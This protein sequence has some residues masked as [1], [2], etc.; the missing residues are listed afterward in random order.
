MSRNDRDV[1]DRVPAELT[2]WLYASTF[3]GR[4][5]DDYSHYGHIRVRGKNYQVRLFEK[6]TDERGLARRRWR[7][8]LSVHEDGVSRS[9]LI[10][11]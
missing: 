4:G 3:R 1:S 8:V 2:G 10:D 11:P 9:G 7:V 5:V 6:T